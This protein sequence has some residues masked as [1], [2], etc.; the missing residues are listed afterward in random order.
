[1]L[2]YVAGEYWVSALL[3]SEAGTSL[4]LCPVFGYL[5]DRVRTRKLPFIGALITLAGCMVILHMAQ[6][7][8]MFIVGRLLQ[9]CAGALVAVAAFALLNESVPLEHLGQTIGYLGSAIASGYLLGPFLG[10]VVYHAAGYNAVFWVAYAIIA[11]DLVLRVAMIE[12]K[13]A[14]AWTQCHEMEGHTIASTVPVTGSAAPRE[15]GPSPRRNPGLALFQMLR[16]RRVLISSGAI[17]VQGILLS[18]FD[19]VCRLICSSTQS[20]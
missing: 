3:M 5:I 16:Q 15:P 13:T 2:K 20:K 14:A 4:L 1:M 11:T 18:A 7:L 17:L 19:A 9:G 8:A 12:K 10:G 6:S